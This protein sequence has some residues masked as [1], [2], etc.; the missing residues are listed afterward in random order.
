[1]LEVAGA[2]GQ[3]LTLELRPAT[4]DHLGEGIPHIGIPSFVGEG[5]PDAVPTTFYF[6]IIKAR[7][8]TDAAAIVS[9]ALQPRPRL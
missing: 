6:A 5:Q 4:N 3:R 8:Q 2:G 7:G 9:T 1:M